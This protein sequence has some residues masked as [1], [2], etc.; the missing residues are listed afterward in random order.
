MWKHTTQPSKQVYVIFRGRWW[1]DLDYE[2]DVARHLNCLC[3]E[4]NRGCLH[5]HFFR[6]AFSKIHMKGRGEDIC[7]VL[8]NAPKLLHIYEC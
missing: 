7:S 3:S 2:Y 6:R 1:L 5:L 8:L 4:T